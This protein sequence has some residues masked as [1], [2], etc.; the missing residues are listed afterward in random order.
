MNGYYAGNGYTVADRTAIKPE[1]IH[2]ENIWGVAD[3]DLFD[4]AI[5]NFDVAH[6]SGK[7]F[8]A[9]VMTTSNHRPYTYPDGRIDMPSGTGGRLGGVKYSDWS[10]GH[11]IEEARKRPWFDNTIFI[12]TADHGANARG[13]GEI[14]AVSYRI[15]VLF[16]APKW[17]KPARHDRLASQIDIP[18]TLL[19]L[20]GLGH[21][22]KFMGYDLLRS[23]PQQDRAFV[24]NY[25]TLG[26][27]RDGRMVTLQPKR[28][29]SIAPSDLAPRLPAEEQLSDEAVMDEAVAWYQ[30]AS[31]FFR[32]GYLQQNEAAHGKR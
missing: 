9:H 6:A 1:K 31:L 7:P 30:S 24:A 17:I 19:G 23:Q 11:L 14:P 3:E 25:Q 22:S 8:F 18:P 20:L 27:L 10:I 15:P 13:A 5:E 2:H 4:Y 12:I 28:K 16:Y 32:Q 29:A 26:Y 21:E